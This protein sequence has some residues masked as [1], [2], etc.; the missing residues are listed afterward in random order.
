MKQNVTANQTRGI[1]MTFYINARQTD[2]V[3]KIS[4]SLRQC[5]LHYR[6]SWSEL[7]FL[8]IGTDRV[9]GD[10]LG[11][12][13]G[14][15]LSSYSGT[16]FSVYG[17]LFQPVH[18]LNL[19]DIYQHIQ[20]HHPNALIIAIDASLGEKKHLGY[21]TIANGALHPGAAIHKQLP[22]VGHIHITGIVN[23]S[24]VLEQLTLQT[25]RLSTVIFLADKIV[26]GILESIPLS[27][28]DFK[29]IL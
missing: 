20:T 26:Q 29:Q 6:N 23:V 2:S 3:C 11:P 21:V 22:S 19:T 15:K 24:G 9:T 1:L 18:A 8:C 16:V 4:G 17:T 28:T 13:V 7:V 25:T 10:C 27:K 14:Q 12:F 5:I